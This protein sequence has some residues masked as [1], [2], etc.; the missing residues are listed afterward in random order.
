MIILPLVLSLLINNKSKNTPHTK[1]Q[2][3]SNYHTHNKPPAMSTMSTPPD[4]DDD[5]SVLGFD[6]S[7][8]TK[9]LLVVEELVVM[10][11]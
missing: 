9:V 5:E 2:R 11:G 1:T 10:K 8:L 3:H 7:S 6:G 4:D